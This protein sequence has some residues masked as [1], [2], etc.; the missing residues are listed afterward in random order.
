MKTI[1]V[2]L[3]ILGVLS[4]IGCFIGVYRWGYDKGT[5]SIIIDEGYQPLPLMRDTVYIKTPVKEETPEK[6]ILPTKTDTCWRDSI[7]Y[8]TQRVDTLKII[9]DYIVKR[10]YEETLFS[11]DTLGTLRVGWETQYNK[12]SVLWYD[13]QPVRKITNY[14]TTRDRN[15]RILMG[16]GTKDIL[17]AQLQYNVND[18]FVVGYQFLRQENNNGL[19]SHMLN[20]GI[21]F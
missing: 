13:Y 3:I 16:I 12:S 21:D 8:V 2:I 20:F 9:A 4:L 5:D 10:T 18:R 7:I 17:S 19:N 14:T 11:T 1:K 6:P 15:F